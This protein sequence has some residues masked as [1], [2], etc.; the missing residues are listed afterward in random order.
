[1]SGFRPP[2]VDALAE[3]EQYARDQGWTWADKGHAD[4]IRRLVS[5]HR[6][7]IATTKREVVVDSASFPVEHTHDHLHPYLRGESHRHHH[8]HEPGPHHHDHH[9]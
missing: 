2:W 7:L 8:R 1:M 9:G 4:L 5:E 3:L 6:S